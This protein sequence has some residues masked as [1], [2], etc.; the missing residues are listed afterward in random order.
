MAKARPIPQLTPEI[1]FRDAAASAVEVRMAELMSFR[2][3]VLDTSDIERV[4]DMRV[5]SR[6]LRAVMEI[7]EPCFPAKE[8][9][10]AL[11]QVK[12]VADALGGRRDPD[13]AITALRELEAALPQPDRPGIEGM[14]SEF[15]RDQQQ[16]N[17]Q[18]AELLEHGILDELEA[19]LS[20][21]VREARA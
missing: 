21:L 7:F 16:A 1:G 3:G 12:Q 2:E 9:G 17:A 19:R 5:A 10:R 14:V 20:R 13:V 8:F 15:E 4:H 6:R 18:L 11:K